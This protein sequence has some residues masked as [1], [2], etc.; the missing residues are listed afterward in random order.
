LKKKHF[1][2]YFILIPFVLAIFFETILRLNNFSFNYPYFI[3]DIPFINRDINRRVGIFKF[4]PWLFWKHRPKSSIENWGVEINS[5]GFRDREFPVE[6]KGS[7]RIFALGDSCTAA[8]KVSLEKT[9]S[10]RLEELLNQNKLKKH[11]EVIN[12][13]I[14]GYS[15]FQGARYFKVI[16][17]KY[18][19]DLVI[20]YFG[21]NDRG[22]ARYPEKDLTL[23]RMAKALIYRDIYSRFKIAQF[24]MK[25]FSGNAKR[26]LS[27]NIRVAPDDYRTN[28]DGVKQKA[29]ENNIRVLF[30]KACLRNEI[31]QAMPDDRYIPPEPF[32]DLY[33]LFIPYRADTGKVFFDHKHFTARGHELI[34]EA[35]YE[36]IK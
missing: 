20:F 22:L 14:S 36:R 1:F 17:E 35:I 10:K 25:R 33:R 26:E 16:A 15:S 28:L 32:I 8:F 29:R 3:E 6:K 24:I 27:W 34:A 4:D 2:L 23:W 13:G 11:Y 9:Y 5:S 19:P 31:S 18:D 7:F 12:G 30:I 21:I